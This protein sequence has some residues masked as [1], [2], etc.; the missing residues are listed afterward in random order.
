MAVADAWNVT[1]NAE[2]RPAAADQRAPGALRLVSKVLKLAV[3]ASGG[4]PLNEQ[5]LWWPS[6][7]WRGVMKANP[8][9]TTFTASPLTRTGPM[10]TCWSGLK[11]RE[12]KPQ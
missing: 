6:T 7:S 2:R 10:S 9:P 4:E 1:G 5:V 3:M 12:V 8:Q 11:G